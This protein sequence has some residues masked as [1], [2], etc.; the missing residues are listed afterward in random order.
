MPFCRAVLTLSSPRLMGRVSGR[1]AENARRGCQIGRMAAARG[2]IGVRPGQTRVRR[3]QSPVLPE[4]NGVR[5]CQIVTTS[6]RCSSSGPAATVRL[7]RLLPLVH[8]EL[9]RLAK[10]QMAG[11][12]PGHNERKA[13]VVEPRFFGG[14]SVEETAEALKI[15]PETVMWDWKSAKGWLMRELSRARRGTHNSR[16]RAFTPYIITGAV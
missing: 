14:L 2:Q 11:E 15:S 1:E 16:P 8:G 13:L 6:Q 5:S 7:D 4:G 9:R 3:G 12:R 10:R